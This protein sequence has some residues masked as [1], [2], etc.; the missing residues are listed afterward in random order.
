MIDIVDRQAVRQSPLG[1]GIGRIT[2]SFVGAVG[3]L[4]SIDRYS[5]T[6]SATRCLCD[7]ARPSKATCSSFLVP[8]RT[9]DQRATTIGPYIT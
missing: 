2:L 6:P 8:S 9:D 7:A 4:T 3:D 1:L 5:K